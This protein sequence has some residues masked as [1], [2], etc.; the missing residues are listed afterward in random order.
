MDSAE[1]ARMFEAIEE[2]NLN[3][4]SLLI[5]RNGAIVTEAYFRGHQ[6][7]DKYEV[8][9]VTKSFTSA[10]VGIAIDQGYIEGVDRWLVDYFPGWSIDH[11]DPNKEAITLEN[12]LTM[13][14]GMG[15]SDGQDITA[16][17]SAPDW[18]QYV[19]DRPVVRE[20][21]TRFNYNTGG[22]Y[23]LSVIIQEATGMNT[24]DFAQAH[25]FEPLGIT[26][27]TWGTDPQGIPTGGWGLQIRPRDMARFGYLYLNDGVWDGQ[28]VVPADWV[29]TSSEPYIEVEEHGEPWGVHYGY[30]WWLH[31]IGYYA[32][33]GLYGQFIVVIPDLEMVAVFTS[34]TGA[35]F[36]QPELLVRDYVMPAA[37]S[38]EPLPPNPEGVARLESLIE[39]AAKR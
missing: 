15:W 27:V 1:L 37:V 32:A 23:L 2:R 28:Q 19:L 30:G 29:R 17:W 9:S 7:E 21:G 12:L 10:L 11:L 20:P 18:A 14:S 39:D 13:T 26:D 4:Q 38:T 24:L 33:S 34:V 35:N 3:L 6:P 8:H 25:L 22:I 36:L 5:V 16:M 31:E